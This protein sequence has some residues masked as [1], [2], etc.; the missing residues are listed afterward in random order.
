MAK[1]IS[2]F[3]LTLMASVVLFFALAGVFAGGDPET[4]IYT[5]G[6]ILIILIAF[7]ISLLYYL[8]DLMKKK[9]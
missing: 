9:M 2:I 6:T 8:I 7:L 4:A 3:F 5:L 1:Y